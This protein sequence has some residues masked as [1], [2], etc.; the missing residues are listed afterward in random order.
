MVKKIICFILAAT[1][2][3]MILAACSM[4]EYVVDEVETVTPEDGPVMVEE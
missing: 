3:T 2:S 1:L 4:N